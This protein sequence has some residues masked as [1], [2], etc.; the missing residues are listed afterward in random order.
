M[1]YIITTDFYMVKEDSKKN[2]S[3]KEIKKK[4]YAYNKIYYIF[5]N[6]GTIPCGGNSTSTG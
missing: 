4:F 3:E 2:K 5:K 6:M 1:E